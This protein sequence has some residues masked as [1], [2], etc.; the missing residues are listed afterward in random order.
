MRAN[1]PKSSGSLGVILSQWP[2]GEEFGG[3]FDD[4]LLVLT[5]AKRGDAEAGDDTDAFAD[6]GADDDVAAG[7]RAAG[8]VVL[9]VA[10]GAVGVDGEGRAGGVADALVADAEVED[11]V[12]DV[13]LD[14]RGLAFEGDDLVGGGERVDGGFQEIV[15]GVA[16]QVAVG[17]GEGDELG[18]AAEGVE[19]EGAVL[20]G[21]AEVF[22][23]LGG[24]GGAVGLLFEEFGVDG[25]RLRV[26][27]V[28]GAG[29]GV[30]LLPA[31]GG[32]EI[33]E[34][35]RDFL[36]GSAALGA[37]VVHDVADDVVAHDDLVAAVFEDETGAMRGGGV[38]LEH[39]GVLR[40]ERGGRG[41][42]QQ[43]RRRRGASGC[44]VGGSWRIDSDDQQ[45]RRLNSM[46]ERA[47]HI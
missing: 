3:G 45:F 8:G 18:G 32:V 10:G 13:E 16:V 31:L 35:E 15:G 14:G 39:G 41:K 36:F 43:E 40:V 19:G 12:F 47:R 33:D 24:E 37:D 23:D 17:L 26:V 30:L 42:G 5:G 21:E 6:V 46:S 2:A 9:D 38:G 29:L 1:S 4:V 28:G 11:G 34:G 22:G 20:F 7:G 27:R 25:G 44:G